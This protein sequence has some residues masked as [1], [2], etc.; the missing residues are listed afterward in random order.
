MSVPGKRPSRARKRF[1]LLGAALTGSTLAGTTLGSLTGNPVASPA[2]AGALSVDKPG[3][4]VKRD[5]SAPGEPLT[6]LTDHESVDKTGLVIWQGNVRVWQ[7]TQALR[8]DEVTLDRPSGLIRA[9]GHVALVQDDGSTLYADHVEFTHGLKDGIG[10]AIYMRMEKNARMAAA[11]TRRTNGLINDFSHAVYTAC[12]VCVDH[13]DEVPF[14]EIKAYQA[15]QDKPNQTIEFDHAWMRIL[16][17]P[18][19][20]FPFFE[21]TDP[22]V[23]R[24]SGFM[25]FNVNPH[26]RFLGTYFTLPY[27]WAINDQSDLM[28][29]PLVASKTGPQLTAEFRERF[30]FGTLD[31]TGAVADDTRKSSRY[32]NAYGQLSNK[33]GEGAQGY[34]FAKGAFAIDRNWQAGLNVNLTTSAN[35]MRDYRIPGYG[36]DVLYTNAFIQGFGVGSYLHFDGQGFQGLN[37]GVVSNSELPYV[38][39]RLTYDYTG[40]PDALGGRF[41]V[42][43]TDFDVLRPK[44]ASDQRGE[45]QMQWDRPFHNRL[46]QQWL[47]T[48]RVDSMVYHSTHLGQQPL[49][50][51]Q[52]GHVAGQVLPTLAVKMNWPFLRTFAQGK[53]SQVFEPIVQV[54]AAPNS[55]WGMTR[56]LPNEDSLSYEFSDTTMFALNRYL[57]TDRLDGGVRGNIGVHQNWSWNGHSIDMLVGESIQEHVTHDRPAYSGLDHHLSDPVGRLRVTPSQ[58]FDATVRGRYNPWRGQFDYGES[59]LSAGVPQF[60]LMG[61]YIYAPVTPY[62]YY[63]TDMRAGQANPPY[64]MRTSEITGGFTAR[65]RNYHLSAYTRRSFT[66][67]EFV[68]NGGDVGYA[69]DCFGLD[70]IYMRQYTF[71]GGRARYSTVLFNFFF[72]TIGTFG[73]NG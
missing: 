38:L 9:R 54:I 26:D 27:F 57:G 17:V 60:R 32:H 71:I 6:Y 48:A 15:T 43:T 31:V 67:K 19:F 10:T 34:I 5:H 56:N 22:T 50:E 59:L 11:G 18:V 2:H 72:K 33:S 63:N 13:P 73:I 64:L 35:Y 21:I 44:G 16:G 3:T 39:P 28:L 20:Y 37:N 66:R 52:T 46:G 42:H 1:T 8:A 47:V 45:L 40:E 49:Y 7:G 51:R 41:S 30:N 61:G 55:G 70:V 29:T 4:L 53:G 12:P 36:D 62:Y 24:H 69:N 25:T 68:A 14:W 58:Y 23:P 65:W